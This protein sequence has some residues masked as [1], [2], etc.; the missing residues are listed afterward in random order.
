MFISQGKGDTVS[1]IEQYSPPI[2]QQLR[3][4][5]YDVQSHEF[6]GLHIVPSA[7]VQKAMKWY[8]QP[9]PSAN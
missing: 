3:H 5:D 4:A 6:N 7:I 2:V 8:T 9:T 1:S